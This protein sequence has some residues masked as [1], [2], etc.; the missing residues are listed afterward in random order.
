[1]KNIM[2]NEKSTNT[3]KYLSFE[4]RKMIEKMIKE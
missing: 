2:K 4:V 3:K 1:M